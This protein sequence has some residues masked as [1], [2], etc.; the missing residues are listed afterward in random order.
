M[1]KSSGRSVNR[2]AS[3]GR[4]VSKA[5]VARSPGKT[6][7]QNV[8]GKKTGQTVTRSAGSGE[9]VTRA[10]AKRNPSGTVTEKR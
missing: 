4:F 5:T 2:S 10:T 3:T 8:G 9:F 1:A 7:T 6:V